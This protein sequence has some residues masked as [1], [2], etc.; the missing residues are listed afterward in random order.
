MKP[1]C[2]S[3]ARLDVLCEFTNAACNS[4]CSHWQFSNWQSLQL[5]SHR[6]ALH[7]TVSTFDGLYR[8]VITWRLFPLINYWEVTWRATGRCILT[9]TTSYNNFLLSCVHAHSVDLSIPWYIPWYISS[10]CSFLLM[11][12]TNG[13]QWI[14]FIPHLPSWS[15]QKL[16]NVEFPWSEKP[17]TPTE[18]YPN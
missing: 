10:L 18:S 6:V 14:T 8:E 12:F 3:V 13:M 2:I 11:Q 5:V 16:T 15:K 4:L 1:G 7:F 9:T 17:T